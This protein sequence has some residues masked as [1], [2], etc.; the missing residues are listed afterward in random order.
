MAQKCQRASDSS[1]LRGRCRRTLQTCW[2]TGPTGLNVC[3]IKGTLWLP[4][5]QLPDAKAPMND[6]N[7]AEGGN[8]P[9]TLLLLW[10]SPSVLIPCHA[11]QIRAAH[12]DYSL[13][14][15]DFGSLLVKSISSDCHCWGSD[16]LRSHMTGS[17][18][19]CQTTVCWCP[20]GRYGEWESSSGFPPAVM[21]PD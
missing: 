3:V 1:L 10:Y 16:S 11:R 5:L 20:K 15:P 19:P 17:I 7:L 8:W 2:G 18:F 12:L 14:N 4:R 6:F 21:E 13:S 9:V